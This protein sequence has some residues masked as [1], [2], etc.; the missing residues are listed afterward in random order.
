MKNKFLKKSSGTILII[1]DE[2]S[3]RSI[4]NDV[5]TNDGYDVLEAEDGEL[6]LAMIKSHKPDLVLLDMVLPKMHGLEVLKNV[7]SDET[8]R[9]TPVLILSVQGSQEDI[10]IGLEF[11]ANDYTVKG[12][13]SPREILSK[14][15]SLLTEVDIK[16]NIQSYKI[17]VKEGH[18]D[19]AKL[20]QDIGLTKL[21]NCPH[22]D[23]TM[24]LELIP[25][26]TRTVGHW[27][28]AHFVCDRCGREF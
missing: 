13:Y 12:F 23:S 14:I 8:I 25:D 15:H 7:R 4:Y 16:K 5:L 18:G 11:G 10:R 24:H 28:S 27:F 9:N 21:C 6:G 20:E 22:C 26:Y 1:E 19:S 3:F 17:E 2:Y